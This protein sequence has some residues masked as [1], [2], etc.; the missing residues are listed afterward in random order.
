M[1]R[2]GEA[3]LRDTAF[4]ALA[5]RRPVTLAVVRGGEERVLTLDAPAGCRALVEIRAADSLDARS[6]GGPVT[7][8]AVI[9]R[10]MDTGKHRWVF[11]PTP[12]DIWTGG[13]RPENPAA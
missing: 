7:T 5:E 13:C 9:A 6:D 8:D 1:A 10:D 11:Q 2:I 4:A 3:P 12:N